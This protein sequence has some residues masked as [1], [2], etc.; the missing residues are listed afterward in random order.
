MGGFGWGATNLYFLLDD[1]SLTN[2]ND[3]LTKFFFFLVTFY[4]LLTGMIKLSRFLE[5]CF[6]VLIFDD[7]KNDEIIEIKKIKK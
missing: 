6:V 3:I 2:V 1:N 5:S 4:F 7:N